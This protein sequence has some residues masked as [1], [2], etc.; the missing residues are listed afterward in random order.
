[1]AKKQTTLNKCVMLAE[2]L[3]GRIGLKVFTNFAEPNKY[4]IGMAASNGVELVKALTPQFRPF[5]PQ[6]EMYLRQVKGME[7]LKKQVKPPYWQG[8]KNNNL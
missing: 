3:F 8:I 2:K 1:M 6:S 7:K 5:R 4:L